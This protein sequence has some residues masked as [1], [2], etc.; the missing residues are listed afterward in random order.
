MKK[1]MLGGVCAAVLL[2]CL[3]ETAMPNEPIEVLRAS[4]RAIRRIPM[5]NGLTL[6]LKPDASAPLV[7]IQYW[8]RAGAIHE[9][10]HLGGGLSHYLE[11]MVFKGTPTRAPG[12]ISTTIADAGG[13]I[14]AYT[15]VDRTVFHVVMPSDK[16]ELGLDVLTDAV[17]HP[18]FPEEEWE[19]EREVV[20]RE[21]AM[22][23]DDPDRVSSRL[24]FESV[25]RVHPYRVPV[26]GWKD[27]LRKMGRAELAA[28]HAAHYSPDNMILAIAGDFD[29]DRMEAAVRAAMAKIPRTP[30]EPVYIP[31][32]PEQSGE[33]M[34]RKTGRYEVARLSWGFHT[35]ELAHEDAPA[36]DVLASVTGAGRGSL[37]VKR[38]VEE[39]ALFTDAG[40][41]SWTPQHPG[42]F[43][44]YGD[45]RP[46][47][48]G[49]A[50]AALREEVERWKTE[51]FGE[52]QIERARRGLLVAAVQQ[53]A[54]VEGLASSM[55]SGEFYAGD[56]RRI[57]S[58]FD[59]V[60]K[61]TPEDLT[62]VAR[63]YLREENGSWSILAPEGDGEAAAAPA[64]AAAAP[65]ARM[66]T[67]SNGLRVVLM[68][69]P[70]L[71][72]ATYA[73]VV[74][75]GQLAEPE[76]QAGVAALA[77]DLLAR[78]TSK[79]T[80]AELAD[81]LEPQGVGVEGYAGRNT[82]GLTVQGL[83][84]RLGVLREAFAECLLEST[85]PADEFARQRDRQLVALRQENE[86]PM[87]QA[88]QRMR[89]AMFPGHPYRPSPK[90]TP[91]SLAAMA[92][93]DLAA[94]HKRLFVPENTVISVFG[95]IRADEEF[96]WLEETFGG[97]PAGGGA[98]SWPALPEVPGGDRRIEAELPFNQTV[99]VRA[100]PGI[101]TCDPRDDDV[102]V[103]LDTLSGLSSDLFKE[104]RDKRGLAYYTGARQF[105][106][107]VGG[108]L[109]AYAGTT[110]QGLAEVERQ[111]DAQIRRLA[112]EGPRQDEV[113]RAVAQMRVDAARAM[114]D[115]PGLARACAV[116]ELLGLGYRHPLDVEGRLSELTVESVRDAARE[117]MGEKPS[118]TVVVKPSA[119]AEADG[120]EG[121]DGDLGDDGDGED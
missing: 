25:Y 50:V 44:I 97:L 73:A 98:P 37:L 104:V 99:L 113:D 92:P 81:W 41:W 33:R 10:E 87:A 102:S 72:T 121:D 80:A 107:P 46:E 62:R 75:G 68:E 34:L 119:D 106:G 21:W 65:E 43:A 15:S 59:R 35:V 26:I 24:L 9:A 108:L 115:L 6:L 84:D 16:A 56:P 54:S 11:H 40:T 109:L 61:V 86:S 103:L 118:L 114:Q 27:I 91:E 20:F 38:W 12:V 1:T 2:C 100:W 88:S 47:D 69:N 3:T 7:A 23:E 76:G 110:E 42:F 101:A 71:P 112:G 64:A 8:V 70:R 105:T 77:A 57:E 53:L 30:N 120:D 31:E 93:E 4:N 32:E 14:N 63:K 60:A 89:D 85:F 19:R 13:E 116:D 58:Y 28:Y 79:H 74:G 67:L 48:E 66:R 83:S 29:P 95:D 55:A 36:L 22:G 17:F 18:S 78:G 39:N 94:F 49:K 111:V 45:C 51:P 52:A 96:A 117:L 82:H 90:G 5:D